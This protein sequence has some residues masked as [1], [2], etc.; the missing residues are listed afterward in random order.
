MEEYE[1]MKRAMAILHLE[2]DA[3]LAAQLASGMEG[4]LASSA[5][6]IQKG[7]DLSRCLFHPSFLLPLRTFHI[8]DRLYFHSTF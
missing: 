7:K 6:Q 5:T 1:E 8:L 4:V 2:R 3:K